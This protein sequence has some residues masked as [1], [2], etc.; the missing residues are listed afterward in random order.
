VGLAELASASGGWTIED[1][2]LDSARFGRAVARLTVHRGEPRPEGLVATVRDHASDVIIAR[3]PAELTWV[4]AALASASR[5]VLPGGGLIYWASPDGPPTPIDRPG[6]RVV[7]VRAT[8]LDGADDLVDD[9]VRDAFADYATHY[10]VDPLFDA[11]G[12]LAGQAEWARSCLRSQ[13]SSVLVLH[14]AE[15][16]AGIA[17]VAVDGD[18]V[19]ILLAGVRR[20]HQ[21][22]GSYAALLDAARTWAH[23]A[24]AGRVVISTQTHN[25]RVQRAWARAG[26]TPIDA[27]DTAH[28]VRHGLLS[29]AMP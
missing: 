3:H 9:L 2:P 21:G 8:P 24:G 23:A 14:V 29:G 22:R 25:V 12:V 7:D 17:T 1:S 5:D 27:F 19:E 18:D 6:V 28:L 20:A 10:S 11:E 16:P 4:P 15:E 26:W 13:H